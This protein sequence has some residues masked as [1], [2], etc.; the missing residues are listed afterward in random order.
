MPHEEVEWWNFNLPHDQRTAT[1]PDFLLNAGEKD[2]RLIG[3]W[4]TDYERRTWDEVT[5]LVGMSIQHFSPLSQSVTAAPPAGILLYQIP[6]EVKAL[7][8]RT[9]STANGQASR[10]MTRHAYQSTQ[11]SR[12]LALILLLSHLSNTLPLSQNQTKTNHTH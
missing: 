8:V 5:E 6:I 9:A 7:L 3:S 4:D 1:C 11:F 10:E 2:K 12:H